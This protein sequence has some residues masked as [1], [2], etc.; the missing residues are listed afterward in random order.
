MTSEN[1]STPTLLNMLNDSFSR[2][3]YINE[4]FVKVADKC[5]L[6]RFRDFLYSINSKSCPEV[7]YDTLT[8]IYETESIA[9]KTHKWMINIHEILWFYNKHINDID[10]CYNW[11]SFCRN[12]K[13]YVEIMLSCVAAL[14]YTY[15]QESEDFNTFAR[16]YEMVAYITTFVAT[17]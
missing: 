15:Q 4:S 1:T 3:P 16:M 13:L 2:H 6:P 9:D 11:E 12:G 14:H 10:T 7:F 8:S 17:K 5:D